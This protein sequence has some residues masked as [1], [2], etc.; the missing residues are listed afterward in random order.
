ML[1]TGIDPYTGRKLTDWEI[2]QAKS[3]AISTA[4]APA[5]QAVVL[6]ML[7]SKI[8]N[9]V[10]CGQIGGDIYQNTTKLLPEVLGRVWREA[11]VGLIGDMSRA[12]QSGTKLLY[13]NDGLLYITTDHYKTMHFIGSY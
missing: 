8:E 9:Y 13:S 7:A 11:D 4:V 12:K 5:Y 10:P 6:G 3:L 2:A 1:V